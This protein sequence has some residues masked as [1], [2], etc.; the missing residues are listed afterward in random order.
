MWL[1]C[2]DRLESL[3]RARVLTTDRLDLTLTLTPTLTLALALA[4][5]LTLT[6]TPTLP[7]TRCLPDLLAL[8]GRLR[9]SI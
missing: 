5:A 7:L 8:P 4:P 2:N 3:S 1:P 6:P 9:A